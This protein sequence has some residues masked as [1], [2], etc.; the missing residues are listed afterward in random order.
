MN[1]NF[2]LFSKN[3]IPICLK[4]TKWSYRKYVYGR[5]SLFSKIYKFECGYTRIKE[6][7]VVY[8]YVVDGVV[9]KK[10]IFPSINTIKSWDVEIVNRC[11]DEIIF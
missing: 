4:I 9:F 6:I 10:Y 7:F 8:E 1:S 5:S 11:L 2:S 3:C